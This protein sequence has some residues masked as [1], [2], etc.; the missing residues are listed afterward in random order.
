[1]C[2]G[3]LGLIAFADFAAAADIDSLP[4]LRLPALKLGVAP[5]FGGGVLTEPSGFRPQPALFPDRNS[6]AVRFYDTHL[7]PRL[8]RQFESLRVYEMPTTGATAERFDERRELTESAEANAVRGATKACRDFLID[9]TPADRWLSRM[10]H[11][12]TEVKTSSRDGRGGSLGFSV[13]ISHAMPELG[14]RYRVGRTTTRVDIDSRG[15]VELD[16]TLSSRAFTHVAMWI[17]PGSR[18]YAMHCRI[19]F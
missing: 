16:F 3:T 4:E 19:N 8:N 10:P 18:W 14:L 13:G 17:D 7:L 5:G 9:L 6:H 15:S 2:L 11:P 1:V 12:S